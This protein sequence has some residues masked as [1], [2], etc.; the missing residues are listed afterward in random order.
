MSGEVGDLERVA[1]DVE[2]RCPIKLLLGARNACL[3]GLDLHSRQAAAKAQRAL[4]V[5]VEDG[6]GHPIVAARQVMQRQVCASGSVRF[7]C[8]LSGDGAEMTSLT[9]E[10]AQRAVSVI[11]L[12]GIIGGLDRAR[13]QIRG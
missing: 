1:A 3:K 7:V 6:I 11:S 12:C 5:L 2:R 8:A 4:R 9:T 13:L 10:I